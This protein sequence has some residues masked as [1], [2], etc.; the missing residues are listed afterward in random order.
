M[1]SGIEEKPNKVLLLQLYCKC[2]GLAYLEFMLM[3]QN[4]YVCI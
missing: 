1:G 3:M 2:N 4:Y